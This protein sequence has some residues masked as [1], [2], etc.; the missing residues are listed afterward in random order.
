MDIKF[1]ALVVGLF[2][3]GSATAEPAETIAY[4][5]IGAVNGS[6]EQAVE[7]VENS[8]GSH[9]ESIRVPRGEVHETLH[10]LRNDPTIGEIERSVPVKAIEPV[11]SKYVIPGASA[12]LIDGSEESTKYSDPYF[13]DQRIWKDTDQYK[14]GHAIEKAMDLFSGQE[15]LDLGVLDGGFVETDDL[16]YAG[17]ATLLN[18]QRDI[19][20]RENVIDPKCQYRHGTKVT[21]VAAAKKG[22]AYGIAGIAN[23]N[24]YAARVVDCSGSGWS[25]EMADAIR[26][27]S[28]DPV[29]GLPQ[30]AEPVD[31]INVS[32]SGYTEECSS[33]LQSAIDTARQMGVV[34]VAAAGNQSQNTETRYPA[35]C[36]GVITVGANNI[37]DGEEAWFSNYGK[38]VDTYA[39]GVGVLTLSNPD[40]FVYANGTSFSSPIVAAQALLIKNIEPAADFARIQRLLH[41]SEKELLPGD[42]GGDVSDFGIFDSLAIARELVGS[43]YKAPPFVHALNHEERMG[44]S[45]AYNHPDIGLSSCDLYEVDTRKLDIARPNGYYYQVLEVPKSRAFTVTNGTLIAESRAP[46]V[47]VPRSLNPDQNDYG[48]AICD[49]NGTCTSEVPISLGS[50]MARTE[51]FCG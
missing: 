2:C 6:M 22:N 45:D 32:L 3:A 9:W 15:T 13:D 40:K 34:I 12:Q 1:F 16:A 26:W 37:L 38:E 27:L 5:V 11:E 48:V 23:V 33:Y 47:L 36:Q 44:L 41:N 25:N 35:N 18:G 30:R 28:G 29:E 50:K 46:R 8:R 31:V 49:G 7:S 14:G 43:T 20:F 51:E 4:E 17:G 24:V 42:R 21:H 10:S 39:A 19:T